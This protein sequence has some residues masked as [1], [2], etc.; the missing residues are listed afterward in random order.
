[1]KYDEFLSAVEQHGGPSNREHADQA[2]KVVLATIGQRLAGQEPRD[3]AS[4]LPPELQDPLLQHNGT[5]ETGDDLDDF[6]RRVADREGEGCGPEAALSHAQAVLGTIATF[7]SA[8]E[9]EDLRTQLP[10]GYAVLF[11]QPR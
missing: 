1:M 8:G 10:T 5:A 11:E 4:Q 2:S 6:L 3:L 9:I 7:V